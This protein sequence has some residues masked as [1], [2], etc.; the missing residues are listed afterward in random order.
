[1]VECITPILR[2]QN[3]AASIDYYVNRL[4]FKKDWDWGNPPHFLGLSRAAVGPS[5]CVKGDRAR[6]EHTFGLVSRM[7]MY[8]MRSSRGEGPRFESCQPTIR[9]RAK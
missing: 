7:S 1:M 6:R 2:V 5:C 3:L 4:G 9:G 8:V